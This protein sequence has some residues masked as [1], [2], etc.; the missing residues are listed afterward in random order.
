MAWKERSRSESSCSRLS[1]IIML[2]C[3]ALTAC[4]TMDTSSPIIPAVS[5]YLPVMVRDT[6]YHHSALFACPC[7]LLCIL[8]RSPTVD[9]HTRNRSM[10]IEWPSVPSVPSCLSFTIS[11]ALPRRVQPSKY[12]FTTSPLALDPGHKATICVQ[13]MRAS[14]TAV[15]SYMSFRSRC[16]RHLSE[17]HH[18]R[19]HHR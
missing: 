19:L 9:I 16:K 10:E 13:R 1:C 8:A 7:V 5:R 2:H 15:F 12:Y 17:P 3:C 14:W 18:H 11:E 4:T 6:I